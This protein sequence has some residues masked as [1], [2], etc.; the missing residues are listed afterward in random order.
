MNARPMRSWAGEKKQDRRQQMKRRITAF[1]L[2]F[3]LGF[4]MTAEGTTARAVEPTPAV[5]AEP[6][7]TVEPT[8]TIKPTPTPPVTGKQITRMEVVDTEIE[9]PYKSVFTKEN[10]AVNVYYSDGT[11]VTVHPDK[12]IQL[13]T[14]KL[15]EQTV[16]IWYQGEK[17]E[18][19][20]RIVP[21]QVTGLKLKEATKTKAT[22]TWSSLPEA[23]EYEIYTSSRENGTFNLVKSVAKTSYE[24]TDLTRG[25]I[26]YVKVRAVSDQ[27]AGADSKTIPVALQ[28]DPVTGITA[29]KNVKTKITLTWPGA[30]GATG[31]Q[32]YYRLS[33]AKEGVLAG[34]TEENTFQVTGLSAGKNYYFWIVAYAGNA[35]NAAAASPEVLYGTAPSIPSISQ[36]KGGDRR[37]K[38]KWT[39]GSGA[40]YFNIYV[41]T[42]AASG[43]QVKAKAAG[44]EEKIRGIDGLKK[45]KTY[46]VKVEAVRTVSGI[47]MSSVSD[48]KN[49][50]TA[51]V[52]AK[53]TSTAA[54]LFA[55]LK[56]FRKSAAYKQYKAFKKRV[57]YKKSYIIPGLK[58]TNVAGFNTTRMVPQSI[59][60][61]GGYLL[62][63]AYDYTKKQESVIYIMNKK[64]RK[65]ITTLVLPHTG[66]IGGIA[67]DGEN[68]WITYGK[69]LQ[70]FKFSH[71]VAAV[72]SGQPFYELY[73][74]SS[75]CPMPETVSYVTYYKDRIWAGAYSEMSK[76]Y[77]YGYA[78]SD[79]SGSPVLTC[80]NRMQMPNRTQGVAF[81]S[82]GK[83]ILSRSC[84]TMKDRRGFMSQLDT[85][86]PT[87]N[88]ASYTI[89]KNSRKKTVKMPPMNE[90]I[91]VSG[92]YT[93]VIY[94]SPSFYECQAPLDRVTAFRTSK[95]S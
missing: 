69:N 5:E 9:I 66:H 16:E 81:T 65:Y 84:Q 51:A 74:F 56:A 36:L 52:K 20:L 94:E 8:P 50:A 18:Y 24:F 21:R 12:E 45:K 3:G 17:T 68:V 47:T 86:K 2:V 58:T 26:R 55:T 35:E 95:I 30:A 32:I 42:K 63:S 46:Y 91:A 7:P 6:T 75:V 31:Y 77:M 53:V 79:K 90:G 76:K 33:T 27:Y 40:D 83:M 13:N 43:F 1:F 92:S 38:V 48:V 67:F 23:K 73:R 54:K 85:Y 25:T 29:T 93:Y 71:I 62:I 39:K 14:Q 78:I 19:M 59:T 22:I 72:N 15:G 41:S 11:V 28:P 57:L 34:A 87:W 4:G 10:I 70:S 60:F 88:L 61:A 80:T 49:T 89:K 44:T 64:T 37:V 82:S